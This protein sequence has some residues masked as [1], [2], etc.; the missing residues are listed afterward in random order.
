LD[1]QDGT[2]EDAKRRERFMRR[3]AKRLGRSLGHNRYGPNPGQRPGEL[4]EDRQVH[5]NRYSL[6]A[7]DPK[8]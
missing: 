2:S 1:R 5:M 8:R 3:V 4:G 7:T 6:R